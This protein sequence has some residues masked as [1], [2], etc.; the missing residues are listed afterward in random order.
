MLILSAC[1]IALACFLVWRISMAV[2]RLEQ[3]IVSV[4]ADVRQVTATGT[5]VSH[6]VDRLAE[7]IERLEQKTEGAIGIDELESA[8]DELK[9]VREGFSR[10]H[11]A[12]GAEAE[13]EIRYLLEHIRRS[14]HQFALPGKFRSGF[15]A[16]V[17]L[18]AKFKLYRSTLT[19]AENFIQ[20]VATRTVTGH[21]YYV[22]FDDGG[23]MALDA[24]LRKSLREY[25]AMHGESDKP[26]AAPKQSDAQHE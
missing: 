2:Y 3:S 16:Y 25:R 21:P 17:H 23:K 14:G 24:W 19:S 22:K 6:L 1:L 11:E 15:R 20:Q 10:A 12:L 13:G 7:R 9:D 18:R 4:G 26:D 8:L 5:R